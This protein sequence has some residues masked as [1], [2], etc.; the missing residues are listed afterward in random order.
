MK[1]ILLI[2]ALTLCLFGQP[3]EAD[4]PVPYGFPFESGNDTITTSKNLTSS[5]ILWGNYSGAASLGFE[6]ETVGDSASYIDVYY[7]GRLS[8]LN[9]GVPSDS[10][11][12]DSLHIMRVDSTYVKDGDPFWIPLA[13][14]DWWSYHDEGQIILA[15]PADLDTVY[16]KSRIRDQR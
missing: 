2:L 11:G 10:I 4:S 5:T 16:V 12:V 9:W 1:A 8:G 7:K 3:Y 13:K 6:F 14:E 15:A